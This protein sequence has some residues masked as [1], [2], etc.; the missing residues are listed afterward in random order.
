[1]PRL[2]KYEKQEEIL[3]ERNSYSKTDNDATFMRM[4]DDQLRPGYNIQMGTEEQ[5]IVG[6]SIHQKAG[7]TTC[8]IPHLNDLEK[9][10]GKLPE[11]IITDAGYGSEENYEYLEEKELGNYVKYNIFHQEQKEKFKEQIFRVE[12]LPYD[13]EKDEFS[14]PD[15]KKFKY[16]ETKTHKTDNGY[17]TER[18]HYECEDCTGCPLREKCTKA[19]GNRKS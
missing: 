17:N 2:Q 6:F 4:K 16:K 13:E 11:N 3:Q 5:F 10:I 14:C 15:G 9:N 12:N 18:R 1:M 19:K 8:L 7:D